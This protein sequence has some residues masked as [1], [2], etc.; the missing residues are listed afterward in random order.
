MDQQAIHQ[1]ATEAVKCEIILERGQ[2][3]LQRHLERSIHRVAAQR[4][5]TKQTVISIG[6][7]DSVYEW[8]AY[9]GERLNFY[10]LKVDAD[11]IVMVLRNG[12][13]S[14]FADAE[15][16]SSRVVWSIDM[17][18]AAFAAMSAQT[19]TFTLT[20]TAGIQPDFDKVKMPPGMEHLLEFNEQ[21]ECALP[22]DQ[23]DT[24]QELVARSEMIWVE[25]V[26]VAQHDQHPSIR[27]YL[28]V[29]GAK[30]P[31]LYGLS[32]ESRD[33]EVYTTPA[34]DIMSTEGAHPTASLSTN[35]SNTAQSHSAHS[36]QLD[37]PFRHSG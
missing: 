14:I 10:E 22:Q 17:V 28:D 26:N 21:D 31:D 8:L 7:F 4:L 3:E 20:L 23:E 9:V 33:T 34:N 5:Q 11:C 30:A 18:E 12:G 19:A 27:H 1:Q 24:L 29:Y 6:Y 16:Y 25:V 15:I 2:D 36:F 13:G 35:R 32:P 37:L